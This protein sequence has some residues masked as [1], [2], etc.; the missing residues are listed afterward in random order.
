MNPI[1]MIVCRAVQFG[2][3]AVLPILPYREPE[4]FNNIDELIPLLKKLQIKSVLLV[5]DGS[6]RKNG[7]TAPLETLLKNRKIQCTVYGGTNPNPTVK[8][9]E[10]AWQLYVEKNVR[11]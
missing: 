2:F 8:N 9:V 3:H 6:L 5:T 7:I 4:M 1:Q 10:A 11:G